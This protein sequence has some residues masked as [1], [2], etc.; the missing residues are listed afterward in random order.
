MNIKNFDIKIDDLTISGSRLIEVTGLQE[1]Q[2]EY[3]LTPNAVGNGTIITGAKMPEREITIKARVPRLTAE[4]TFRNFKPN[5][6]MVLK[7]DTRKINVVVENISITYDN[8]YYVDPFINLTLLAPD[9]FFY[10]VSDF[11]KNIAG[12]VP[13]FSFPWTYSPEKPISFGYFEFTDKTIFENNGDEAVGLKLR[14]E[15]TGTVQNPQ[16][17]NLTNGQ[18]IKI[19]TELQAGD[20]LEFSTVSAD[21]YVRLNGVDIFDQIDRL[22]DFF[23]LAVGDNFLQYSADV[24][25]T[26]MDIYLYYTPKY[27]SGLENIEI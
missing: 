18:F 12:I 3:E 26:E 4:S 16:F 1:T 23:Q 15:A 2:V 17:E 10:D 11:G 9:P 7:I 14:I 25:E 27:L 21:M 8:G 6:S 24:G 22:S 20:I 5:K 19:N 13:Q